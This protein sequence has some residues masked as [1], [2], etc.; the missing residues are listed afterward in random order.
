M[1][2]PQKPTVAFLTHDW[3]WGT[4]PLQPNGCAWYRCKLPSLELNKRGWFSAVGFPIFN[5]SRGF[6]MAVEGDKAVHG[7]DIIVLKL[8]MQQ[9][10]LE[11][12]P[13][14][15]AMGQKIIVD[16]DDWFEGLS[17]SNRAYETTDPKL[18]PRSNREIYAKIIMAADAV[19]TST[20]FLFDFY[21]KKRNNVFLVR[22]GIDTDR[23]KRKIYR[24]NKKTKIGWAGATHWRSNDLEQLSGFMGNY[25]ESHNLLFHHAGHSESAPRANELLGVPERLTRT[26]PI[27][28]ILSYPLMFQNIDIGLIPLNNLEFNYAKSFIKGLEYAA[29]GVPFIASYSPEYEYLSNSGIGRLARSKSE[30]IYHL[31]ELRDSKKRKDDADENYFLLKNFSM[32]ARGDDWDVTMKFILEKL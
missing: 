24:D 28:P 27:V 26:S 25:L 9:E 29:A 23:W 6:G 16:V 12:I 3:S 8:L 4:D 31:D 30:W 18:N 32:D 19:I 17:K 22:N 5:T 21:G 15:Q 14:A 7:W 13:K 20:P 2:K 1:K 10:V 11:S